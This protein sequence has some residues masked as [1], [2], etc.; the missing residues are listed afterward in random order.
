[1]ARG[2]GIE[3]NGTHVRALA[4]EN[5]KR[6]RIVSFAEAPIPSQEDRPWSDRAAEAV[7]AAVAKIGGARGKVAASLDTGDAVVRELHVPF[8]SDDQ[9]R[10]TVRFEFEHLVHNFAIEDLVVDYA[11]AEET[12]KGTQLLVAGVPKSV[13]KERLAMLEAAGVDPAI[14]DLDAMA[15][16]NALVACGAVAKPNP[17]LVLYG[18]SR[19]TK[20]ILVE[21][22]KPRSIRTI[23]FGLPHG[24]EAKATQ[25]L[26]AILAKEVGRFLMAAAGST[27]PEYMILTG[28][29]DLVQ[30]DLDPAQVTRPLSDATGIPVIAFD[31]LGQMQRPPD[32]DRELSRSYLVPIGLALKAVD[33]DDMGT[34][35][36]K[37]EFAYAKKFDAVRST[38][39][40]TGD[41]LV[42]LLALFALNLWFRASDL[43]RAT[44][45]VVDY[46]V[47]VVSDAVNH[48]PKKIPEALMA[49]PVRA[50]QTLREAVNRLSN[51]VGA[52][53][54]PIERSALDLAGSV[55]K[56]F[57][58]FLAECQDKQ[59][60]EETFYC[61]IG[62]VRVD[63]MPTTSGEI[64]IKIEGVI[65]NP[66]FGEKLRECL[67]TSEP[68]Q[69]G[70]NIAVGDYTPVKDGENYRFSFA[71][72]RVRT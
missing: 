24:Q 35:F 37:N 31:A 28:D 44:E 13:V 15:L 61:A 60:G 50:P 25:E 67:A 41:L 19:F 3:I 4:L 49:D 11:R 23:R 56:A 16:F 33:H 51:E 27:T 39:L 55:W 72:K 6:S 38:A 48:S 20:I 29:L 65:R 66:V 17:F 26:I 42:L 9:I 47:Q 18:S 32:R 63:Q 54:H 43:T 22:R 10:K 53:D 30:R 70:W 69:E 12:D 58:R 21:N 59:F 71:M 64:S 14:L 45:A 40:V 34:D 68:F 8:K 52:G 57:R 46:Q 2:I 5:G 62:S 36:R 7:R 1:M